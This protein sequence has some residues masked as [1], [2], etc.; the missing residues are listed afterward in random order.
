MKSNDI[1]VARGLLGEIDAHLKVREMLAAT[2][3]KI[4]D[5]VTGDRLRS[6]EVLNEHAELSQYKC[7]KAAMTHYKYTCFNWHKTKY[8]YALRHL[9]ALVN[10]CERGYSAD[11]Y[12]L[13]TAPHLPVCL[14]ACLCD[15]S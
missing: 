3:R 8:E 13:L 2:M 11:R 4:V 15:H 1:R 9:Y 7:Y 10:L 14:S 6:E 12:V 5:M